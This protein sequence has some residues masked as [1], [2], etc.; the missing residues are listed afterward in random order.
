MKLAQAKSLARGLQAF[1]PARRSLKA[2]R[3]AHSRGARCGNKPL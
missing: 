2:I 1:A 3:V